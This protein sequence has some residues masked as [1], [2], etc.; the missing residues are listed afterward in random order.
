[1]GEFDAFGELDGG[2]R[3]HLVGDVREVGHARI[4]AADYFYAFLKAKVRHVRL[5]AQGIDYEGVDAFE[6]GVILFGERFTV[7]DVSEWTDAEAEDGELVV[8]DWQRRDFDAVDAEWLAF[9]NVVQGECG[10]AGIRFF[11]EAVGKPVDD[12]FGGVFA[13]V[14]RK[15]A[16]LAVRA[17]VVDAA[18]VVVVAVCDEHGVEVRGF[19]A[20][21]L[22]AYVWAAVDEQVFA[23]NG[24]YSA[25][26]Q[27]VVAWVGR[28][29]RW[30]SASNL[31]NT[32]GGAGAKEK[33]FHG[34]IF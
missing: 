10:H 1:M 31:R 3:T 13:A 25:G 21:Q 30:A 9:C 20:Y 12:G 23:A 6:Q 14:D 19:G 26:A 32:R 33:Q 15:R 11:G 16:V 2:F 27:A 24:E 5:V 22:R 4:Y 34:A 8:H 28:C 7:S 18:H 17:H 29:A